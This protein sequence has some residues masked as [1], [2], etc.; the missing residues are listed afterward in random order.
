MRRDSRP[1]VIDFVSTYPDLSLANA[2]ES[3]HRDPEWNG[4]VVGGL[5]IRVEPDRKMGSFDELTNF[6]ISG[7]KLRDLDTQRELIER[8]IDLLGYLPCLC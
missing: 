5:S 3:Y 1:V 7:R 4:K 2:A 6:A 8:L